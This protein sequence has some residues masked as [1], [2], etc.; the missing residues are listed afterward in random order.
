MGS[1]LSLWV[2]IRSKESGKWE[3]SNKNIFPDDYKKTD[4]PFNRRSYRL[5]SFLAGIRNDYGLNP[6]SEQKG[7]PSD[8]EYLNKPSEYGYYERDMYFG[9]V[10]PENERGMKYTDIK[11][12]A[13]YYGHSFIMLEELLS[14][15]YNK[16]FEDR[17]VSKVIKGNNT[18]MFGAAFKETVPVGEGRII[19]YKEFLDE[20]FF[21]ELRLLQ[22][23]GSPEDVRIVFY[24]S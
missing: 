14:F 4:T 15:D 16:Q 20:L 21:D 11:Y 2:E 23:L 22:T 7:L 18:V 24:F 3:V 13:N 12:D 5:F 10:I 9:Q 1:D 6:I 8:S 17:C 19:S